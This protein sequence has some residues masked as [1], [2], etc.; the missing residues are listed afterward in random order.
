T[1]TALMISAGSRAAVEAAL[2][3]LVA[4]GASALSVPSQVGAKW[5]A[6]C[7]HPGENQFEC[8]VEHVGLKRV[9]TGSSRA[10]VADKVADLVSYG[11]K[12]VGEIEEVDGRWTAI[13]DTQR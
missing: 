2:R 12:L 13:C 4:K 1:G 7:T 8:K 3:D 9:I 11:A 6:S 5:Y 10:A